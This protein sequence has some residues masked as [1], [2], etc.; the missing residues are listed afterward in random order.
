MRDNLEHSL[1]VCNGYGLIGAA[2]LL[3]TPVLYGGKALNA[4]G[5]PVNSEM[6][7]GALVPAVP[8]VLWT[9]WWTTRR[10]HAKLHDDHWVHPQAL[11]CP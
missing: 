6:A 10:I 7:A 11:N 5:M 1:R 3:I 4:A 2:G 9:A 8:V